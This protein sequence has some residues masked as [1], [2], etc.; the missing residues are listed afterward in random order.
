MSHRGQL[1]SWTRSHHRPGYF[2]VE[3]VSGANQRT[4]WRLLTE[5]SSLLARPLASKQEVP[6]TTLPQP[7]PSSR[8]LQSESGTRSCPISALPHCTPAQ[9]QPSHLRLCSDNSGTLVS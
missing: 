4:T 1:L 7:L 2:Q 6:A 5:V 9:E 3:K 8:C